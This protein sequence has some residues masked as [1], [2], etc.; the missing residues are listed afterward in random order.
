LKRLAL[1]A[2]LAA[3]LAPSSAARAEEACKPVSLKNPAPT[4]GEIYAMAEKLAKAWKS[5][6]L[7]AQISNT[8][9]G[10]LQ[11]NGSS[12]MWNLKF[13]SASADSWV[14]ITTF[15]GSLTCSA[16]KGA[17]GRMPDLKP[18]LLRRRRSTRS[19]RQTPSPR[20]RRATR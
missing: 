6:A 3:A 15:R 7:P 5:D 2:L 19:R 1:I 18:I 14:G 13:Y 8:S 4:L 11:P 20:S 9:L 16:E 10:P 17:A 12:A